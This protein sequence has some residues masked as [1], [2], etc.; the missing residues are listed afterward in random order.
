M[1]TK[2]ILSSMAALG[3]VTALA[4]C[5]EEAAEAPAETAP[6]GPDGVT[7]SNGWMSLPAV[8]GN[9][10]A[11]YFTIENSG[12]QDQMIRAAD[13]LGAESA[14]MHQMSTWNLEESM[15]ELLQLSV[16]AGESVTFEPGGYHVMAMGV[17]EGLEAGSETE[18]TLTFVRGDKLSFPVEVRAP[19][20]APD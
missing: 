7:V 12:D 15:D 17:S 19:G 13:V 4:A 20:D 3:L 10:A 14:V 6:E 11:I 9:P 5:S 1:R 18:V 16:P 2:R 8:A